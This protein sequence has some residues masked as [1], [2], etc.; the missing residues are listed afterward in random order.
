VRAGA[1]LLVNVSNDGWLDGGYGVA[2]RQHFAMAVLRA[3]ESGRYLVRA[4]T[5]GESGIID[6]YGRVLTAVAPGTAG[7]ATAA[8]AGRS[9][10]TPYVRFG[11]AFAAACAL[12][13]LVAL[14]HAATERRRA[15]RLRWEHLAPLMS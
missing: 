15:L 4:A 14:G 8:V 6:P 2:G 3:V 9:D 5:T 11:D 10:L 7:L 13:A 1:A 12:V